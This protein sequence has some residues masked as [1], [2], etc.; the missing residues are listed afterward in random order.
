M[1]D[2]IQPSARLP[3][4]IAY[5]SLSLLLGVWFCIQGGNGAVIGVDNRD[6]GIMSRDM[7]LK[8]K[9][10]GAFGTISIFLSFFLKFANNVVKIPVNQSTGGGF[11]MILQL[12][13][14]FVMQ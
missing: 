7:S 5:I 10:G 1:N 9:R 4:P 8:F 11:I 13:C 12:S 14:A 3:A 2:G 6:V